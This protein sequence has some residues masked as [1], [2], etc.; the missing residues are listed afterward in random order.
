MKRR[1]IVEIENET[2][3]DFSALNRVM[4]VVGEGKVR[5]GKTGAH[6]GW[7]VQFSDGVVVSVRRKRSKDSA[8][9]FVV[10]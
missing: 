5:E 6:Y 4:M 7:H 1:I 2:I 8:D 3:S 10:Y 9:S